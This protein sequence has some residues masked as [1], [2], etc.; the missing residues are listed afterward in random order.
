[1]KKKTIINKTKS[2]SPAKK[3]PTKRISHPKLPS[4]EVKLELLETPEKSTRVQMFLK[5]IKDIVEKN[6]SSV[7]SSVD[8]MSTQTFNQESLDELIGKYRDSIEKNAKKR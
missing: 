5:N 4:T 1:M 7:Q 8:K 3:T 2:K 6:T